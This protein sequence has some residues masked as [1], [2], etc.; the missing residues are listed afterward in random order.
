[1]DQPKKKTR[2]KDSKEPSEQ[3]LIEN[4]GASVSSVLKQNLLNARDPIEAYA[5][6][7]KLR[8]YTKGKHFK[9]RFAQGYAVLLKQLKDSR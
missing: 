6:R 1:M 8:A 2:A 3:T 9:E 4:L 5:Y 7:L